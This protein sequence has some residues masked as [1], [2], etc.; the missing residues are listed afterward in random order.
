VVRLPT[1]AKEIAPFFKTSR[2][3]VGPTQPPV[4]RVHAVLPVG[5]GHRSVWP[6]TNLYLAPRLRMGCA[7]PPLP[8]CL[9]GAHTDNFAFYSTKHFQRPGH[10]VL[11]AKWPQTIAPILPVTSRQCT[12]HCA[13]YYATAH[14]TMGSA[15]C[16]LTY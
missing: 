5:E 14:N 11:L 15:V 9:H 6:T 10:C 1:G 3:L 7:I 12:R 4:Q 13:H 8:I 2:P 16:D